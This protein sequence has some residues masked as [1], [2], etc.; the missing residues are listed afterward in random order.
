MGM[1]P[2]VAGSAKSTRR[3]AQDGCEA[4]ELPHGNDSKRLIVGEFEVPVHRGL[5]APPIGDLILREAK[6][7]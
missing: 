5:L 1:S 3:S 2:S 6:R 7:R 4:L